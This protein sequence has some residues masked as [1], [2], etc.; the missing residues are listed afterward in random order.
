MGLGSIDR[1]DWEIT[2]LNDGRE[3]DVT[4]DICQTYGV[5]YIWTGQRHKEK[6]LW[7]VPGFALNIGVK[8][9]N[10]EIIAI[11]CAEMYHL[12]PFL[13]NAQKILQGHPKGIVHPLEGKDDTGAYLNDVKSFDK[14]PN[15]NMKLPFL[16]AMS[17]SSYVEIG[18][19]DEDFTGQSYDDNDIVDRL[20][21]NGCYYITTPDKCVHLYHS[22]DTADKRDRGRLDYNK[23]LYLERKGKVVRNE[24]REWGLLD[25]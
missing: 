25:R 18:G 21:A 23:K 4:M 2:V 14:L 15:L 10:D 7:R 13:K 22:R 1:G 5:D 9:Y 6:L 11:S 8:A 20:I 19:Y 16:M 12:T 17:R 3:N 24:N